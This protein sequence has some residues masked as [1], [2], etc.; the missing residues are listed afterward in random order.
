LPSFIREQ[1][2]GTLNEE[3][4]VHASVIKILREKGIDFLPSKNQAPC[5]P[6]ASPLQGSKD[7]DIG[8][9]GDSKKVFNKPVIYPFESD[10]FSEM[11]E[12]WKEYKKAHFRFSFKT[13]S[14]EQAALIQL[15]NLA[16]GEEAEAIKIITQSIA[17]G[18]KGLFK[19]EEE[20]SNG[21]RTSN[22]GTAPGGFNA[23][24][25]RDLAA[26]MAAASGGSTVNGS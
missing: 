25:K 8:N 17:Q 24:Y 11:W 10:K 1:Y 9:K 12:S 15:S 26:R 7:K 2:N 21:K 5:K 18:W 20:Q 23:D 19:I 13:P 4:K 14:S 22:N 16:D 6:L 3:N